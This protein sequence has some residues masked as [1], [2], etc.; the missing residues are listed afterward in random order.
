MKMI[1]V[2]YNEALDEEVMEL[3]R[4]CG[5]AEFTKW[6]RTLGWGAQSEPHLMTHVWPKANNV[7]MVCVEDARASRI[8]AAVRER[9]SRL[10]KEGFKAFAWTVDEVT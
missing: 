1:M 9:R 5:Q 6:T 4:S 10:A 2:A 3:L 7:L 8:M